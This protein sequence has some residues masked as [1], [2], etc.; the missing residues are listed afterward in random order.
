MSG[1][2][3]VC[4]G[5][6]HDAYGHRTVK[7]KP[8]S[9]LPR[10][11]AALALAWGSCVAYPFGGI[12]VPRETRSI[13]TSVLRLLGDLIVIHVFRVSCA[14]VM[15]HVHTGIYCSLGCGACGERGLLIVPPS[16]PFEK[17]VA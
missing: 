17:S 16:S 5:W 3:D 13:Q 4:V 7:T 9:A 1:Y 11:V 14:L 6:L 12:R 15:A 8:I 2:R 10:A